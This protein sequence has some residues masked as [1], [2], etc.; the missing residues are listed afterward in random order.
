MD[1][2]ANAA[3]VIVDDMVYLSSHD[4]HVYALNIATGD[5]LWRYETDSDIY[6]SPL[7]ADGVL[8]G[9]SIAG[10]LYAVNAKSGDELWRF[11]AFP[12]VTS[13]PVMLDGAVYF[14]SA[15]GITFGVDSETGEEIWRFENDSRV[16]FMTVDEGVL[17]AFVYGSDVLALLPRIERESE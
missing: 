8:Y 17:Y 6:F 7:V 1:G 10:P 5:V 14:G 16:G 15:R 4:D 11:D 13:T 3:P 12:G 2:L 9:G